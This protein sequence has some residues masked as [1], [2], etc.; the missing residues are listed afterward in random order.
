MNN[1]P[2]PS[3]LARALSLSIFLVPSACAVSTDVEDDEPDTLSVAQPEVWSHS[4]DPS[5]FSD[6][7][8]RRAASLP[9]S[10][11]VA[12]I[13]WVGSYWPTWHDS[14]NDRWDGARSKSPAKKF[15]LAFRLSGIEDKVSEFHG[16]DSRTDAAMCSRDSECKADVHEKCAKR[17]GA[18]SGRCIP[19]WFGLCHAWAAASVLLP[20]PEHEVVKNGVTF[21]V[22][23]LKALITLAHNST[24]SKFVSLR[25]DDD[26]ARGQVNYDEDGRPSRR[27]RDTNAGTFHLLLANYI[28]VR[29]LPFIQDRSFDIQVWNQPI[30]SFEVVDRRSVSS[31]E[32]NRLIGVTPVGG[33]GAA[34]QG[35]LEKARW[36]TSVRI[37]VRPR[38]A[39]VVRMTGTGDPDLYVRFDAKPSTVSYACRPYQRGAS[40]ECRGS[41]P[42]GSRVMYVAVRAGDVRSTYSF[43]A[44]TGVTPSTYVFNPDAASLV[45][46]KTNVSY[47]ISSRANDD[48]NLASNVDFFTRSER[49]EYILELDRDGV[50]VGGEWAGP[51]KRRHPDFVWLPTGPDSVPI[52]GGAISYEAVKELADMSVQRS[53]P[54]EDDGSRP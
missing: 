47:L 51:S 49:Y 33:D 39:Y 42:A 43:T 20:E 52:A 19:T 40:E 34:D 13:P 25:C 53:R 28:G 8:E 10:G 11:R 4:D 18:S 37:D 35:A 24:T 46:M 17:V 22:Q 30:R 54:G 50:I 31:R 45:Y 38:D 23:D 29:R 26:D 12:R 7:L 2:L 36:S 9:T 48:G 15:E 27:C 6:D 14:I 1:R 32:A 41:V 44:A 16:I 21:K 3:A 5:I